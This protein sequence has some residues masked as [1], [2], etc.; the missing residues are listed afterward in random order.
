MTDEDNKLVNYRFITELDRTYIQV[1]LN[2]ETG[3]KIIT[4]KPDN[5]TAVEFEIT[6]S[7]REENCT[8]YY[9]S[10]FN[11]RDFDWDETGSNGVIRVNI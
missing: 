8:T 7:S 10:N 11:V 2:F 4:M 9:I 6:L 1:N 3:D 5:E